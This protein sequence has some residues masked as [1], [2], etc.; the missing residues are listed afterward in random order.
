[1]AHSDTVTEGHGSFGGYAFGFLVSV[2]LTAIAFGVVL[3]TTMDPGT[4]MIIIGVLALV[5]MII[6]MVFFLHLGQSSGEGWNVLA[7]AYTALAVAFL[8]FG[9]IWVMHNVNMLM[10]SR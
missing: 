7:T 10:M 3:Y 9:T 1:M 6:H 5:Q 2:V 4:K 8:V